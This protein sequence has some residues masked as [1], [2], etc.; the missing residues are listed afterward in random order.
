MFSTKQ[1][2]MNVDSAITNLTSVPVGHYHVSLGD[3]VSSSAPLS[4]GVP[5][6]SVLGPLRFSL[7]LLLLCAILKKHGIS[8]HCYADDSLIYMPLRKNDTYSV[9]ILLKCLDNK[10]LALTFLSLNEKDRS[11]GSQIYWDPHVDLGSLA[12]HIKPAITNLGVK[13]DSDLKL[14]SQI[15][16]AVK[17]RVFQLRQLAKIKP[18][19]PSYHFETVIHVFVTTCLNYC[20][21]LYA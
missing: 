20:N 2:R 15:R 21:A 10:D 13:M 17:S 1:G 8:L 11:N 3:S 6:G 19:L 14:N 16:T 5:Q 12:Q 4:C 7:Y 18:S 9:R